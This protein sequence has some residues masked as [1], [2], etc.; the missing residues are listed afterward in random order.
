MAQL[1]TQVCAMQWEDL[2]DALSATQHELK[3]YPVSENMLVIE[4]KSSQSD[5]SDITYTLCA[6][7]GQRTND[8]FPQPLNDRTVWS[9]GSQ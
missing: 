4:D 6:D 5:Q 8:R 9:Y 7:N 1:L 2:Q 3:C